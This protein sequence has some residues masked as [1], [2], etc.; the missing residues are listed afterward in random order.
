MSDNY[1]QKNIAIHNTERSSQMSINIL[2][3][4]VIVSL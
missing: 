4:E 3:A 2:C 1:K